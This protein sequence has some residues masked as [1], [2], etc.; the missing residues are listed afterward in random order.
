MVAAPRVRYQSEPSSDPASSPTYTS[1]R[2]HGDPPATRA[3]LRSAIRRPAETKWPIPDPDNRNANL[4]AHLSARYCADPEQSQ[5]HV[6]IRRASGSPTISRIAG[7]GG[8]G[9]A[10]RASGSVSSMV[11]AS[12][13]W[14]A[15][16]AAGGRWVRRGYWGD[17]AGGVPGICGARV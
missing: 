12:R 2:W 7:L 8:W 5:S 4:A 6:V 11:V 15:G 10:S 17:A 13:G 16:N 14:L 3:R 1:K 9:R